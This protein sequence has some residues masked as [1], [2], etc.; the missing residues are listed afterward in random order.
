MK[1]TR[2]AAYHVKLPYVGGTYV[3]G[4]GHAISVGLST[5]IT[6]DTDVGI[7]GCGESCPIDGTYLAA[8][9]EGIVTAL[10]RLATALLGADPRQV[11]AIE[12]IMDAHPSHDR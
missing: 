7:S 8:Y 1:I 11:H 6:I 5:V 3:W 9:P 10:V 12:R 2:I 4:R